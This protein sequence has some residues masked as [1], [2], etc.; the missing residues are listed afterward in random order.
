MTR[1]FRSSAASI[2]MPD[3]VVGFF[4]PLAPVRVDD[5]LPPDERQEDVGLSNRLRDCLLEVE[6]GLDRV[7]VLED[8]SLPKWVLSH[9]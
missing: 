4:E 3:E 9:S 8:D 2:S 6:P 7:H 1:I 5:P